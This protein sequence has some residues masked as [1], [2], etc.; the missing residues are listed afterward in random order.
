MFGIILYTPESN[1]SEFLKTINRN[2]NCLSDLYSR[3]LLSQ[4]GWFFKIGINSMSL[5]RGFHL[6]PKGGKRPG[7]M[8]YL[9]HSVKTFLEN[10]ANIKFLAFGEKSQRTFSMAIISWR[11][12]AFETSGCHFSPRYIVLVFSCWYSQD[13]VN[14][15]V[16]VFRSQSNVG[17]LKGH[18]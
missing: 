6:W 12:A 18:L 9:T 10:L 17:K 3:R 16:I 15:L 11:W 1:K 8:Y 2:F 7:T 14:K 4:W 5:R 13:N